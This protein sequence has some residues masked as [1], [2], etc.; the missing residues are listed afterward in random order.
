MRLPF[1]ETENP[2]DGL[3]DDVLVLHKAWR[4][5]IGPVNPRVI[6]LWRD[7]EIFP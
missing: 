7:F 1:K 2:F 4:F 3:S 5:F 6:R